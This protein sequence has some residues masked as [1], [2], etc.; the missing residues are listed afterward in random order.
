MLHIISGS[1]IGP[2][3]GKDKHNPSREVYKTKA[4]VVRLL[5][6]AVADGASLIQKQ[7]RAG[8]DR[9]TPFEWETGRHV[10]HNSYI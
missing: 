4:D 6:Q 1:T 9:T 3:F 8:L 5:Q 7:G 2:D 10:A